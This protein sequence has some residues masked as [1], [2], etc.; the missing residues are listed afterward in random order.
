M[1]DVQDALL[2]SVAGDGPIKAIEGPE[3]KP[4]PNLM[5]NEAAFTV[6][7]PSA[8]PVSDFCLI[9]ENCNIGHELSHFCAV[10]SPT[11]QSSNQCQAAL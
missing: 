4:E 3:S 6:S 2:P 8:P 1:H 5:A 9:T 7:L 10:A 11:L